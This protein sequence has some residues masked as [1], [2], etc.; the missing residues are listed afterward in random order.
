MKKNKSIKVR[1][2]K[3]LQNRSDNVGSFLPLL[4]SRLDTFL[5][6]FH[7]HSGLSVSEDA[8]YIYVEA[9]L[10]GINAEDVQINL[11]RGV[12][13][14]KADKKEESENKKRTFYRKAHK[15]FFYQVPV[16]GAYDE[17]KTPEAI[18]KDG[19]LKIKFT[20]TN[21]RSLQKNIKVK[22]G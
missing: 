9:A 17:S 14:V 22:K 4:N 7:E 5:E 3:N 15:S 11:D 16:P 1:E 2:N 18:C 13:S 19:I 12:L 6:P 10:P 21:D 20:K 8:K